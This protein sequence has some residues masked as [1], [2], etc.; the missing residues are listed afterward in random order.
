M[1]DSKTYLGTCLTLLTIFT[2]PTNHPTLAQSFPKCKIIVF[3][4]LIN[5][6]H[7]SVEIIDK[8]FSEGFVDND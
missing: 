7:N 8:Y 1:S 5:I 2:A 3:L 6:K 4:C